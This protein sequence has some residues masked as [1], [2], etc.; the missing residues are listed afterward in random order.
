V[1]WEDFGLVVVMAMAVL[2]K[3]SI[4]GCITSRMLVA[5]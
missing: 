5:T 2:S 4:A 3:Y 1:V